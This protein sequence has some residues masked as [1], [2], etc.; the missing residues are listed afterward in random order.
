[1]ISFPSNGAENIPITK[2]D[3]EVAMDTLGPSKVTAQ[4]KNTMTYPGNAGSVMQCSDAQKLIRQF[5]NR[6]ELPVHSV[7]LKGTIFLFLGQK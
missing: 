1:M 3:V 7:H 4:D 6:V 5:H 2:R